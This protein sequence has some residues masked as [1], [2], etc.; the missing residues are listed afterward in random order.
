MKEKRTERRFNLLDAALLLLVL[1]LALGVWQRQ[2]LQRLFTVDEV[3]DEYTVTFEIKKMRST[4]V[5]LLDDGTVFYTEN[6]GERLELGTLT[7]QVAASAA[8]VE[9]YD[10]NGQL[11]QAVYPQD[12]YEY[13]LDVTGTLKCAGVERDGSFLLGG[14]MYLAYNKT[15]VVQTESADFEILI[16]GVAKSE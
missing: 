6:E 8:R 16:T 2:N 14:K 15:V 7:G 1:L 5:D 10:R 3:L 12:P 11:V 9:L 13:L 4:T